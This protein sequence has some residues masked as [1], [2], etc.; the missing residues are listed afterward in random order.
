MSRTIGSR[1]FGMIGSVSPAAQLTVQHTLQPG[2]QNVGVDPRTGVFS[3]W[4]TV[5]GNYNGGAAALITGTVLGT[6]PGAGPNGANAVAAAPMAW[7]IPPNQ[8]GLAYDGAGNLE[9]DAYWTYSW[10]SSGKLQQMERNSGT[11]AE[12]GEN[13]EILVFSYDADGRRTGATRTVTYEAASTK[14]EASQVLWSGWLPVMEMRYLNGAYE[15]RRW[16]QWGVDRS[17]TLDGAGGIGG[18]VAILEEDANGALV[19]TLLPVSDGLGNITGV[20]NGSTGQLVARYDYGPF[21]EPLVSSGEATA[22]PFQYQ[23]KW[24]DA[25]S[26][27]YYFGYRYYDP[28]LGRWLSRDPMGEAGGFNLYAYCGNDPVNRHDPLGLADQFVTQTTSLMWR[29][30]IRSPGCRKYS[31]WEYDGG[32]VL[33]HAIA[34]LLVADTQCVGLAAVVC[35]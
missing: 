17:G 15:G 12:A 27:H 6:L 2:W 19:R 4:W 29:G 21:G 5:P 9:K 34:E 16:F 32:F 35:K 18:L 8:E 25:A 11:Y 1:G 31:L 7:M 14:V 3:A 33:A 10:T 23:S 13:G 26:Q 30:S 22:C 28:R 24:L 20:I